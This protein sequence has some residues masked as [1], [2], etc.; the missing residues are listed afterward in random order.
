MGAEQKDTHRHDDDAMLLFLIAVG[1][2]L[3]LAV[4]ALPFILKNEKPAGN[5]LTIG[6]QKTCEEGVSCQSCI[7]QGLNHT[8]VQGKCIGGNCITP[9]LGNATSQ[10]P[11]QSVRAL[12]YS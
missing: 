3:V 4:I 1:V 2:L 12:V 8:C 10:A 6:A 9:V 7:Q 11:K 5:Q